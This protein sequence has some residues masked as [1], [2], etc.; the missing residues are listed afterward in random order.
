MQLR[1]ADVF[2]TLDEE[3]VNPS[4]CLRL[5]LEI[6]IRLVEKTS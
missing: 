3:E 2:Y 6:P 5:E 4:E 1:K